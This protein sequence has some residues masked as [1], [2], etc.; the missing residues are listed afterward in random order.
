MRI[1]IDDGTRLSS[2]VASA[3]PFCDFCGLPLPDG[4]AAVYKAA[5]RSFRVDHGNVLTILHDPTDWWGCSDCEQIIGG[6]H[7]E[8]RLAQR[9]T[10][11]HPEFGR[12]DFR[13]VLGL[14]REV[15]PSLTKTP[16]E[17]TSVN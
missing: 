11:I 16:R 12:Q 10:D 15:L 17:N 9:H 2:H 1:I 8:S 3:G 6:P 7:A 5:V 14:F 4:A 13:W